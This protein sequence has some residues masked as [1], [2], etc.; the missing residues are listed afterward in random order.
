[1]SKGRISMLLVF[2]LSFAVVFGGWFFTKE[3]LGRKEAE[4]LAGRGRLAMEIPESDSGEAG[5]DAQEA[6]EGEELSEDMMAEILK[7]WE[8]GGRE[9]LHEPLAGQMDMEQAITAGGDWIG[10]MAE[11]SILPSCLAEGLFDSTSAVLCTL[12]G[13]TSLEESLISYWRVTYMKGGIKIILTIHALSGQVW[14]ADISMR[15]DEMMLSACSEEEL[16]AA[17]FPFI[18]FITGNE[19]H[20][21]YKREDIVVNKQEPIV[22][23]LFSLHTEE[24]A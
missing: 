15:E 7:V 13:E 10:R 5:Y 8:A 16:L 18:T 4:I 14:N 3:M 21:A 11:H 12:D 9:L 17:A 6:F 2:C 20:A 22:R 19:V 1:M 23:L 24:E